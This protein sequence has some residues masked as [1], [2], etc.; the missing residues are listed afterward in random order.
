P[1]IRMDWEDAVFDAGIADSLPVLRDAEPK[2]G[3]PNLHAK[4]AAQEDG[5][6]GASAAEIQ[7]PH[8]GPQ[9]HC[10]REP[11]GQP[12]GVCRAAGVRHDPFM[13]V[14]RGARKALRNGRRVWAHLP[15]PTETFPPT[16]DA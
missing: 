13:I 12:E 7:H 5:R 10:A 6:R 15:P 2:I 1:G 16:A 3:C 9:I 11:L 8:A 14:S 4:F